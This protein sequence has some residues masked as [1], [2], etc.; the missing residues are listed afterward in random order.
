M[1]KNNN[2]NNE[3]T[4][5]VSL[6]TIFLCALFGA[7]TI[8][9]KYSFF[10][11]GAFTTA[12]IRFSVAT[13]VLFCW[14]KWTRKSLVVK[15]EQWHHIAFLTIGFFIQL[16]LFNLGLNMSQASR[17][18]LLIN[19]LPFLVLFLAHYFIPDDRIT[20][21]KLI[22]IFSGFIGVAF[23]FLEKSGLTSEVKVGDMIILAGTLIWACD[24]VYRKRILMDFDPLHLVF[25]PMA[26]SAP[27]FFIEAVIWDNP[28][29][30]Y[31]DYRIMISFM[32]QSL[33]TASFGF[34]A[35]N[36]LLQKHG[37]VALYSFTFIMPIIGI[38][39]S[40]LILSEPITLKIVFSLLFITSGIF[41]L[42]FKLKRPEVLF[43]PR[44]EM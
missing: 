26:F 37:A 36:Y 5:G 35:W 15:K 27:L 33:V 31:L 24:T 43:P 8:A 12:G 28:M 1:P 14:A 17:A 11:M 18:I 3:L 16:S 19:L 30:I 22:G 10:G 25:Y 21:R 7:N 40:N 38:I 29:F 44:A 32:Y 20:I 41:I 4:L 23:I 39:L 13:L 6:Y 9:I 2:Q 34:L 42:N